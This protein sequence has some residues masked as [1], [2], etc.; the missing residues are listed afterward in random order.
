MLLLA[1]GVVL[2]VGLLWVFTRLMAASPYQTLYSGLDPTDAQML[3]QRLAVEHVPFRVSANGASL[4]VP[5]DQMDRVRMQMAAQ[6][7]PHSGQ[8][9]WEIFDK[10]NWMG[11]DFDDQ[12]DYQRALEGELERTILT[13]SNV[14]AARVN[15]VLGHQSL[16]TRRARPAKASVVVRLDSGGLSPQ[17]VA[18]IQHLVAGA[19]DNLSAKNV[20]VINADDGLVLTSGSP[21]PYG[22]RSSLQRELKDNLIALLTPVV[23][24]GNVRAQVTVTYHRSTRDSD[25]VTYDPTGQV[26]VSSQVTRDSASL[27]GAVGIPGAASNVPGP[28]LDGPP[29]AA[30][31]GKPSAAGKQAAAAKASGGRARRGTGPAAGGAPNGYA[32]IA[33]VGANQGENRSSE[34]DQYVVSHEVTHQVTPAGRVK[35]ISAAILINDV[36]QTRMVKGRA[37]TTYQPRS[38]SQ[39][40]QLRSLAMAAIGFNA[41]RG[42]QLTVQDIRFQLP[43]AAAP[44]APNLSDRMHAF[45]ANWAPELRYAGLLILFLLAYLLLFR[46]LQKVLV[47]S[48]SREPALGAKAAAPALGQAARAGLPGDASAAAA[49]GAAALPLAAEAARPAEHL[50]RMDDLKQQLM[51]TVK[52]EPEASAR[53]VRHWIRSENAG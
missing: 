23:G 3:A 34:A 29:S 48:L 50:Q 42:D 5:A 17:Q 24:S 2:A 9:G 30:G 28:Q 43:P 46:P 26:L 11:S 8:M 7:L 19:V 53:L 31:A 21:A 20:V 51:A 13:L 44:K 1:G 6:G 45:S 39:M 16:F 38:A 12:V 27:P 15:L 37:V 35:S 36:S 14:E 33:A 32:A 4:S 41:Q 52:K 18:G 49:A 25:S 40:A 47:A 22:P 10:P